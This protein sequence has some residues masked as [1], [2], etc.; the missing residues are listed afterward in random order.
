[1]KMIYDQEVADVQKKSSVII[2]I[3]HALNAPIHL[4]GEPSIVYHTETGWKQQQTS[5]ITVT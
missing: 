2:I 4:F 3:G 1:M 5:F